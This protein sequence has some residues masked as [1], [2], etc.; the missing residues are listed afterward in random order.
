MKQAPEAVPSEKL[1]ITNCPRCH[2]TGTIAFPTAVP[3]KWVPVWW[4]MWDGK[5]VKAIA[6]PLSKT[7][8][9][10][11]VRYY[12]P[13]QGQIERSVSPKSVEPR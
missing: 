13:G 5:R 3:G 6:G 1:V 2:G 9:R 11:K 7:G 10:V 8:K 4:T 12:V